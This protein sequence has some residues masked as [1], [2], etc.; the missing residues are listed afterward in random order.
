M[1][2]PSKKV[3]QRQTLIVKAYG[4]QDTLTLD[5]DFNCYCPCEKADN[6]VTY[7]L[8]TLIEHLNSLP[9]IYRH[10]QHGATSL[11][12]ASSV[13]CDSE[14]L[15][16]TTTMTVVNVMD[17]RLIFKKMSLLKVRCIVCPS[18]TF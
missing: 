15:I 11:N 13:I 6:E 2:C 5:I 7:T 12:S 9:N 18:S 4:Y 10:A 17:W 3:D 16:R 8:V 14:K 1:K